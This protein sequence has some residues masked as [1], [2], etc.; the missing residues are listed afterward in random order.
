MPPVGVVLWIALIYGA[1]MVVVP[2]GGA[3][4]ARPA[5]DAGGAGPGPRTSGRRRNRTEAGI[6]GDTARGEVA[7]RRDLQHARRP[8]AQALAAT[9]AAYAAETGD[10]QANR[11]RRIAARRLEPGWLRAI[12]D[13]QAR[14][15]EEA[16]VRA[17]AVQGTAQQNN[18]ARRYGGHEYAPRSLRCHRMRRAHALSWG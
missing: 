3:G 8:A 17:A 14:L 7:A 5:V 18:L 12:E 6:E 15:A 4:G 13:V 10:G 2:A 16:V 1:I 11:A 9:N